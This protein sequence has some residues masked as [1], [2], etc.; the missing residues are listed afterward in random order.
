[1][2]FG[3]SGVSACQV[4]KKSGKKISKIYCRFSGS[5]YQME[6]G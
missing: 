6:E 4:H 1:M 2:R 5:M 3:M